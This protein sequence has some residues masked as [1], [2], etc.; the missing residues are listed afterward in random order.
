MKIR[1][2]LGIGQILKERQYL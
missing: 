1:K 2:E